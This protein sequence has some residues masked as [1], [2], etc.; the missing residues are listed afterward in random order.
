MQKNLSGIALALAVLF[1]QIHDA[2]TGQPLIGVEVR[3][4]SRTATTDA[5][6][7]YRLN[8]VP[9]GRMTL[10]IFSDDVPL[11][12]RSV[13]VKEPQTEFDFKACSTTLD[14]GCGGGGGSNPG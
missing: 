13:T 6:G 1:G 12:H 14:Y 4:G 11:Q 8:N 5:H 3:G 9:A 2:T 7:R 10:S